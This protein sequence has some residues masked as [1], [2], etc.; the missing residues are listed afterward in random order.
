VE[1]KAT[2]RHH[3]SGAG[4]RSAAFQ[5]PNGKIV[6]VNFISQ[7]DTNDFHAG[8]LPTS[9]PVGTRLGPYELLFSAIG[10]G[11]MGEVYSARAKRLDS[12]RIPSLAPNLTSIC[13]GNTL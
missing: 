1:Q 4:H 11:G 12:D 7:Y 3:L 5:L 2:F 13:I 8:G 10:V 9:I 6:L